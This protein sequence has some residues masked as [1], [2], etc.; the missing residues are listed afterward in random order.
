MKKV[1]NKARVHGSLILMAAS[2]VGYIGV[3][4][5]SKNAV[6]KGESMSKLN[7]DF[8]RDYGLKHK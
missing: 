7:E 5:H 8:H 6:R 2:I 3:A 4:I 1:H